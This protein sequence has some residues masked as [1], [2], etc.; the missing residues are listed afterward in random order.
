MTAP[1]EMNDEVSRQLAIPG[2][3]GAE[4]PEPDDFAAHQKIEALFDMLRRPATSLA[5]CLDDDLA[6]DSVL[7]EFRILRPLA[8]G[9]M[10]HV[11]LARQE[12]LGRVVALKVCKPDMA[13]DPRIKSRFTAEAH[14]L[15]Q[16]AH[17][18]VVPVVST[19]EDRGYLYL[20]MEYVA[21]PTLDQVLQAI[22]TA[23]KDSLA[24]TVVS[25][26]LANCDE[27]R[28]ANAPWVQSR[29]RLDRG[30][31]T[32]I[33][34]KLEQVAQGLAAA[35]AA[36][37]L[38]RDIKPANIVFAASGV[39][40][41]VDFGLARA[42]RAPS[43]TVTGEFYGT[44][45]YTSPE[46]A[47]GDADAVSP[48]SGVFSLGIVLFESLS[49]HRPFPGRSSV[50]VLNAIL[51][52]DPPLLRRVEKRLPWEL[53]AIADKCLR[54]SPADRYQSAQDLGADLRNYLE[55]RPVSARPL[56][57]IARFGRMLRRRPWV[58]GFLLASLIAIVLAA[59]LA[60][61]AWAEYKAEQIKTFAKQVDQGDIALF[62]CLTATRPNWLPA[63]VERY[64]REGISAYTAALEI[65]PSAIR[66]LVQRARLYATKNETLDLALCDLDKARAVQPS[67][68]SI[69]RLRGYVLDK[70][71]RKAESLRAIKDGQGFYPTAADDLYWLGVIATSWEHDAVASYDF[72]SRALMVAPS[73]Y[74]S[75][76]ER[77]Y[78]GQLRSEDEVARAN[79]A[80]TEYEI[81]QTIRP[82]LPFASEFLAHQLPIGPLRKKQLSEQIERFGLDLL[83]AGD[84]A[85]LL[86]YEGKNDE[87]IEILHKVLDQDTG[88]KT[89][90]RIGDLEY[91]RGHYAKAREWYRHAIS[92]GMRHPMN[93]IHLAFALTALKDWKNA[94]QAYLDGIN[95]NPT[96]I[97]L[98]ISLG[99][100]HYQRGRFDQAVN[101]FCKGCQLS[102][103]FKDPSR[104]LSDV[105]NDAANV[106]GCH[107]LLAMLLKHSGRGSESVH[108][109][110]QGVAR[111]EEASKAIAVSQPEKTRSLQNALY[112]IKGALGQAY[113][114]AGRSQDALSL[115]QRELARRPMNGRAGM[116]LPLMNSLG[117]QREALDA[118][119][120]IEFTLREHNASSDDIRA[121]RNLLNGQL[122]EMG[123][124]KELLDRLESRRVQ[125]QAL[126]PLEYEWLEFIYS[127]DK[128]LAA[129][130]EAVAMYPTSVVL[131]TGLMSILWKG[132]QKEEAWKA[133]EHARDL[134]FERVGRR[135]PIQMP[136]N[137]RRDNEEPLSPMLHAGAW[138][139]FL[140]QEGRDDE[141]DALEHHFS[142]VCSKTETDPKSLLAERAIAEFTSGKYQ[143]A[144]KS[145]RSC[146]EQKLGNEVQLTSAL[147]RTNRAL[148]RRQD[149]IKT[150]RRAVEI[151]DADPGLLSEFLYLVVQEQGAAGVLRELPAYE[152]TWL[153][154]NVRPNATLDCFAAWA[155]LAKGD[156]RR[157]FE[158]LVSAGPFVLQASRQP[159]FIGDEALACAVILH[160]VSERLA[161]SKRLADAKEFLKRFPANRVRDM[162]AAFAIASRK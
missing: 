121:V 142:E 42:A 83:R 28:G 76:L 26:V 1:H 162:R 47:R 8:S 122:K 46:Q 74:W 101:A 6:P 27:E 2:A 9:G 30:Y 3:V 153:K 70:L 51:N 82:D 66:P 40:K 100:W 78:L 146:L 49:L 96:D 94:E 147:A 18:N 152:Q 143:D 97:F 25:R 11:Y 65:E 5:S 16:L 71:G 156:E 77:A 22:R 141:L 69:C 93:Y 123:F 132:G 127:G 62:R 117:M 129:A 41:I 59:F 161:D 7:G 53:E 157:A 89:A 109:L 144:V 72:F 12:S 23:P 136:V 21:G 87:A 103:D 68:G 108:V 24:S 148:G 102:C 14:A 114:E 126:E 116:L 36:G 131:Q 92:Q 75:R 128:A 57:K 135:Q 98:C 80:T 137:G 31:Q 32:W 160:I 45:F 145:L 85:D 81:A 111:L 133:Y 107:R 58:A 60:R 35:H 50:D 17:P 56:S 115:V 38:H 118:C 130:K 67:F 20:A 52:A 106:A 120:L 54:K 104:S 139:A 154:L 155:A 64:R 84:L 119:R 90:D 91:R 61:N 134:Y 86:E 34:E 159:D 55:L 48:A 79:R 63:V 43:I 105:E 37:I 4:G 19:G 13:S 29:A 158:K 124:T 149:A 88:G 110:E 140:L 125:G 113:L 39:P 151:S 10:G 99:F 44:P 73:D 33:V 112:T 95:Q 138:Y 15:A 150:Y